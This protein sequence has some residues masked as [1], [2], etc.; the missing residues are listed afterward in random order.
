MQTHE[1]Q[2]VTDTEQ[3]VWHLVDHSFK[4]RNT[5]ILLEG[6]AIVTQ[7]DPEIRLNFRKSVDMADDIPI[8]GTG[9][10]HAIWLYRNHPD[11]ETRLDQVEN[12]TEMNLRHA[13]MVDTQLVEVES[14]NRDRDSGH[15][16]RPL[17]SVISNDSENVRNEISL[18]DTQG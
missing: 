4:P 1:V 11:L 3:N 16:W 10:L 2:I 9:L 7:M 14:G 18:M 6:E 13:G 8:E 15:H 12:P 5:P 17:G